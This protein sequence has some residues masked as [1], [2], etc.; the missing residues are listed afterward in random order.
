MS[1]PVLE[2][3]ISEALILKESLLPADGY[4]N[5]LKVCRQCPASFLL[6]N[7]IWEGA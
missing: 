3:Y 1:G 2:R 4:Y 7:D 6:G 5:K